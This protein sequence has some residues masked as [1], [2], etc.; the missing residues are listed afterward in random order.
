MQLYLKADSNADVNAEMPMARFS[1]G[2]F[3][4]FRQCRMEKE[5]AVEMRNCMIFHTF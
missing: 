4:G 2:R 3:P 5:F 1:N